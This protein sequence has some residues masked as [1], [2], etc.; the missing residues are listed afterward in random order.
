MISFPAIN[1]EVKLRHEIDVLV[2][3]NNLML[4]DQFHCKLAY[5]AYWTFP[6]HK[7]KV[8][9][10]AKLKSCWVGDHVSRF[11]PRGVRVQNWIGYM[12]DWGWLFITIL[13]YTTIYVYCTYIYIYTYT[14]IYTVYIYTYIF[15]TRRSIPMRSPYQWMAHSIKFWKVTTR[16]TS[17]STV[18]CR[19]MKP[20]VPHQQI[21]KNVPQFSFEVWLQNWQNWQTARF[22]D[23]KLSSSRPFES[24]FRRVSVSSTT[25]WQAGAAKKSLQL[26][27]GSFSPRNNTHRKRGLLFFGSKVG[28]VKH[29]WVFQVLLPIL[30]VVS[31]CSENPSPECL[32]SLGGFEIEG[33][34]EWKWMNTSRKTAMFRK[35]IKK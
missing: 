33:W 27:P 18:G 15:I 19:W 32:P 23:C 35:E 1:F 34:N 29:Q 4:W 2:A 21:N 12:W 28:R 10:S 25:S 17:P 14:Y 24:C 5:F 30:L 3:Y 22:S 11:Y 6:G 9:Q 20:T 26:G 16:E 13:Q 8:T 31:L 7:V